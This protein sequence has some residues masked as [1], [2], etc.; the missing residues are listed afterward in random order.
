MFTDAIKVGRGKAVRSK[1]L[2]QKRYVDAVRDNTLVFGVGPA[3]TGKTYLAM[4]CAV[5]ALLS[6]SVRRTS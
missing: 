4:A 6:G 3:G 1:T 2:G 5:E